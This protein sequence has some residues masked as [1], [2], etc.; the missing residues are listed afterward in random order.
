MR[1]AY[2]PTSGGSSRTSDSPLRCGRSWLQAFQILV[3]PERRRSVHSPG[4]SGIRIFV[5]L[6]V[7]YLQSDAAL[8]YL[9]DSGVVAIWSRVRF[10]NAPNS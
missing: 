4:I 10:D 8:R 7:D 2:S 1:L 5:F 9:I 6:S 3:F